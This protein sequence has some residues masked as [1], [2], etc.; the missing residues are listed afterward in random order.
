V[1]VLYHDDFDQLSK[2]EWEYDSNLVKASGGQVEVSPRDPTGPKGS[3]NLKRIHSPLKE[4]EGSLIL[5]KYDDPD[6]GFRIYLEHGDY[7]TVDYRGWSLLSDKNGFRLYAKEGASTDLQPLIGNLTPRPDIWY[8]LLL[9][10]D[11]NGK[12]V[13][14]VW[15]QDDPSQISSYRQPPNEDWEDKKWWFG[16][17]L[18]ENKSK[19]YIDS[20]TEITFNWYDDF[21]NPKYDNRLDDSKWYV[22]GSDCQVKQDEGVLVVDR[23]SRA[24]MT[25]SGCF[26]KTGRDVLGKNLDIFEA[27]V[28]LVELPEEGNAAFNLVHT[29]GN[30]IECGLYISKY[31]SHIRLAVGISEWQRIG[32]INDVDLQRWNN[33]RVEIDPDTMTFSC[34]FNDELVGE[35]V[36]DLGDNLQQLVF[37]RFL[38]YGFNPGAWAEIHVDNVRLEP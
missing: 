34:Y 7:G 31:D 26:I 29:M 23:T 22:Q 33:I 32:Q 9:A 21:D 18:F 4:G 38:Q 5:F 6:V 36:P 12:M 30:W 20:F 3:S 25:W 19:V 24:V 15:E 8:Y 10:N 37:Q 13:A 35:T 17:L 16:A 27:D 14:Q 28:K 2:S 1:E 11:N